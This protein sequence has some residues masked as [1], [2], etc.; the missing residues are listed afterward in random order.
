MTDLISIL[1]PCNS[2]GVYIDQVL[3]FPTRPEVLFHVPDRA[4]NLPL[5]LCPSWLAQSDGYSEV[6]A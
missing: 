4:F 2:L 3:K 6:T 5:G 1:A